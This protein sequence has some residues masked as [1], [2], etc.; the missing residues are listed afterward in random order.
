MG[1]TAPLGAILQ[2]GRNNGEE[3]GMGRFYNLHNIFLVAVKE[4][5]SKKRG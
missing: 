1:G 3:G 4:Q 5:K 2:V